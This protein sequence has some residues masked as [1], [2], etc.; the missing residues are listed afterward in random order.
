MRTWRQYMNRRG[1]FNRFVH[2]CSVK[3]DLQ[4]MTCVGLWT[5]SSSFTSSFEHPSLSI[6]RSLLY[7]LF[8]VKWNSYFESLGTTTCDEAGFSSGVVSGC[9]YAYRAPERRNVVNVCQIV[10]L[11]YWRYL[12]L[13]SGFHRTPPFA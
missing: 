7:Q 5:K 4:L 9:G 12:Q 1:G 10:I 11:V 6:S 8:T 13:P 2:L 3:V